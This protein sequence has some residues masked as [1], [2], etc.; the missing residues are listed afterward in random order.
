VGDDEGEAPPDRLGGGMLDAAMPTPAPL[1]DLRF[2]WVGV[3]P[4]AR[5]VL[6]T[7]ETYGGNGLAF[8]HLR[9]GS[10]GA[11]PFAVCW[12]Y[13]DGDAGTSTAIGDGAD[14]G[15][16]SADAAV[17]VRA[18]ASM[19][20]TSALFS[21]LAPIEP[22]HIIVTNDQRGWSLLEKELEAVAREGAMVTA[23]D[24]MPG[25]YALIAVREARVRTRYE[26][27]STFVPRASYAEWLAR[28]GE[29]GRVV[30]AIGGDGE[31]LF[32]AAYSREGDARRYEM[33][34][35]ESRLEELED[36]ARALADEGYI[37]TAFGRDGPDLLLVGT[38]AVG[39][40]AKREIRIMSF[41]Q[42][43]ATLREEQGF[44]VVAWIMPEGSSFLDDVGLVVLER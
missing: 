12:G 10:L 42:A 18:I 27:A 21:P 2:K 24:L 13:A 5:L 39:D 26:G 6:G 19:L 29:S 3:Q 7:T 36:R 23:M 35:V 16:Q 8:T 15:V 33:K 40:H 34:V 1:P 28:A 22:L 30:T 17:D 32:V 38:R 43:G 25:G 20:T 41:Q 44:A 11:L 31:R 37:I 4:R 14:A 9:E